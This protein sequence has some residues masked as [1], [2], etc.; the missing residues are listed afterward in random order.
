MWYRVIYFALLVTMALGLEMEVRAHRESK[1]KY[2]QYLAKVRA[3]FNVT[4]Q[5]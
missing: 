4:D 5:L 2:A 3:F 1:L